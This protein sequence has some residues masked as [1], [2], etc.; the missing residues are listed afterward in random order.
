[1]LS[2]Q[3]KPHSANIQRASHASNNTIYAM[4]TSCSPVS[5]TI[6]T[7]K[8]GKFVTN[9]FFTFGWLKENKI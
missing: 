6:R 1:M 5:S 4:A 7:T 8:L 3:Q 9:L 2:H